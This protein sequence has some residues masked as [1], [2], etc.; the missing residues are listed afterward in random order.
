MVFSRFIGGNTIHKA[1]NINIPYGKI[2]DYVKEG[3]PKQHL[4]HHQINI[5]GLQETIHS[6]HAI[7]LSSLYNPN[8][9]H[10]LDEYNS[11]AIRNGNKILIDA[12]NV[13]QQNMINHYS[14]Y[15]IEKYPQV[16]YKTYQM[17]RV[18]SL[19]LLEQDLLK[20]PNYGIKMVRGAYYNE[21]KKTGLLFQT[22]EETDQHYNDAIHLLSKYNNDVIVATHNK[23]SCEIALSYD[24][25]FKY[26]QL[27][28]MNDTL[29]DF[30]RKN[31]NDVYKYIPYG[32]WRESIPYLTRRLYENIGMIKYM[33]A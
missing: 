18:D 2:F 16:F 23:S 1:K 5:L 25:K 13:E 29:S 3:N 12:E 9:I 19:Q 17:Y 26:A 21:D 28:G 4:L 11:I 22:K 24:K 32:N 10:Y 7:K 27:L 15:C 6:M 33:Y 20:H 30:L 8:L 14:N 31:G